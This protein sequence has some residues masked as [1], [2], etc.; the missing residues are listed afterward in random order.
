M[1]FLGEKNETKFILHQLWTWNSSKMKSYSTFRTLGLIS[2]VKCFISLSVTVWSFWF[3]LFLCDAEKGSLSCTLIKDVDFF[4]SGK[5][6]VSRNQLHRFLVQC[7]CEQNATEPIPASTEGSLA[8]QNREKNFVLFLL[9]KQQK[10]GSCIYLP[11]KTEK[12]NLSKWS[13][14]H[15]KFR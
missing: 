4:V 2:V 7:L 9:L 10:V 1:V 15:V 11:N 14:L 8:Y 12:S 5:A 13:A 3:L 6:R